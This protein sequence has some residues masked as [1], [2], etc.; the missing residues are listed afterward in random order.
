MTGKE[1][2]ELTHADPRIQ[3]GRLLRCYRRIELEGLVEEWAEGGEDVFLRLLQ[4]SD[5]DFRLL[6]GGVAALDR[7]AIVCQP[8]RLRMGRRGDVKELIRVVGER[9][10]QT[11][12]R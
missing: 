7:P 1:Q 2:S 9:S 8:F 3:R 11:D 6:T 10:E 5:W 12:P 4:K